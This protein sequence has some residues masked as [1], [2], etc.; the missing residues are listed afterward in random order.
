MAA[1]VVELV[2]RTLLPRDATLYT[3]NGIEYARQMS[4]GCEV[5]DRTSVV[6]CIELH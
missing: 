4:T 5:D 2:L 1:T 6:R 3:A